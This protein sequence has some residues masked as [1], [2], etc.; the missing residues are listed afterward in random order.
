MKTIWAG[1]DWLYGVDWQKRPAFFF[2]RIAAPAIALFSLGVVAD[3]IGYRGLGGLGVMVGLTMAS[4]FLFIA[5]AA[6][7]RLGTDRR[8]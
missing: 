3:P 6:M 2:V 4:V 8:S 1:L 7:I 5:F